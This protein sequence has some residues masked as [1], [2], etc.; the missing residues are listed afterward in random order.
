MNRRELLGLGGIVLGTVG[1]AGCYQWRNADGQDGS[2]S[3]AGSPEDSSESPPGDAPPESDGQNNTGTEDQ[4]QDGVSDGTD[5]PAE[6]DQNQSQGEADGQGQD[7]QEQQ[8]QEQE[9]EQNQDQN[10]D[11]S[12]PAE[13]PQSA[14]TILEHEY[15]FTAADDPRYGS[16]EFSVRFRFCN[17]SAHPVR[18][19]RIDGYVYVSGQPVGHEYL[20]YSRID[21]GAKLTDELPFF[22]E[23]P[24]QIDNYSLEVTAAQWA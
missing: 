11:Q 22:V 3:D 1:V 21:G 5:S 2:D 23:N 6:E 8:D 14:V 7:Q 18:D 9:Q 19:V 15:V 13:D 20:E 10:Q 4:Q 17:E 16:D 12:P 24:E